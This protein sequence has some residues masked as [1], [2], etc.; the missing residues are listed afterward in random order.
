MIYDWINSYNSYIDFYII[1][2]LQF[3]NQPQQHSRQQVYF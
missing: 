2:F 1:F 3:Y